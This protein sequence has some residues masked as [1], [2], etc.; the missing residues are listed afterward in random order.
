MR[1]EQRFRLRIIF[2]VII[3]ATLPCYCSGLLLVRL[4]NGLSAQPTETPQPFTQLDRAAIGHS[5]PQL[6]QYVDLFPD[7]SH[8][9]PDALPDCYAVQ[10]LDALSHRAAH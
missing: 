1:Q 7:P 5:H 10:H 9:Q 6:D 2:V 8:A 4:R 3:L